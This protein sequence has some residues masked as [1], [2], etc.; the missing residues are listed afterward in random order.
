MKK[1]YDY[2]RVLYWLTLIV[3]IYVIGR[4]KASKMDYKFLN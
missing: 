1:I 4:I 2:F 3:L